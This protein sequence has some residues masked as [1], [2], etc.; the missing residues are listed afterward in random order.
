[1][2]RAADMESAMRG[3]VCKYQFLMLKQVFE[4]AWLPFLPAVVIV[5]QESPTINCGNLLPRILAAGLV[6]LWREEADFEALIPQLRNAMPI[7]L[8]E[9]R[10]PLRGDG[11]RAFRK[12]CL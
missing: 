12:C 1:M 10:P 9:R 3:I 11:I 4:I 6:L 5:W 2:L 8:A 7:R